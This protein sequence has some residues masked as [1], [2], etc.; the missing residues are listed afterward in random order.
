MTTGSRPAPPC[1]TAERDLSG[2]TRLTFAVRGGARQWV[3][4]VLG[5]GLALL[6]LWGMQWL[7]A[8]GEGELTVAGWIFLLV[9]AA[10]AAAGAYVLDIAL[11]ARTEYFLEV[12][13]F[14]ARRRSLFQNRSTTVPGGA[15][16]CIRQ[17]YSPPG[18]SAPNGDPGSWTTFVS[19]RAD[20]KPVDLALDGLHTPAEA[21]WLGP[22]LAQWSDKP[23]RRGFGP[24]FDEADAAGLPGLDAEGPTSTSDRP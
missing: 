19:H 23:L 7:L 12:H 6:G 2:G 5:L 11:Y 10:V 18:P 22:L 20:G 13:G 14:T 4:V 17:H 8:A 21:A 9:P 1:W 3:L 16:E 15:I 24:A